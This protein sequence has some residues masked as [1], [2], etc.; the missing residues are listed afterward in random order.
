MHCRENKVRQF[1]GS[2]PRPHTLACTPGAVT[3]G[4]SP[5]RR[6]NRRDAAGTRSPKPQPWARAQS[7][8]PVGPP[9]RAPPWCRSEGPG[10]AGR[11]IPALPP[12]SSR[13]LDVPAVREFPFLSVRSKRRGPS[14]LRPR[15][16]AASA[17]PD[18]LG[19]AGVRV[20]RPLA[21]R[22]VLLRSAPGRRWLAAASPCALGV[23]R[24]RI[25]LRLG[26]RKQIARKG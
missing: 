22:F 23:P 13:P 9:G 4:I 15:G 3:K 12:G 16:Q 10:E 18:A 24:S 20:E 26:Y 5:R 17:A 8:G 11:Q 7:G 25:L 19:R 2:R 21:V 6:R 14:W 1:G